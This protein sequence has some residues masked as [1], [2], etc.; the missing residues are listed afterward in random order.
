[1]RR[2]V[3]VAAGSTSACKCSSKQSD[4]CWDNIARKPALC[5]QC[6]PSTMQC[7][8]IVCY[9]P[10]GAPKCLTVR[11]GVNIVGGVV[12]SALVELNACSTGSADQTWTQFDGIGRLQLAGSNSAST[13][14]CLTTTQTLPYMGSSVSIQPC[15]FSVT[16]PWQ[17]W[18]LDGTT[19]SLKNELTGMCLSSSSALNGEL[20]YLVDCL[21]IAAPGSSSTVDGFAFDFAG[22][23]NGALI[24]GAFLTHTAKCTSIVQCSQLVKAP[25]DQPPRITAID[26]YPL[27]GYLLTMSGT[28]NELL[29]MTIS[30]YDPNQFDQVQIE[31]SP[32]DRNLLTDAS[33]TWPN[34]YMCTDGSNCTCAS[35]EAGCTACPNGGT[36]LRNTEN[37]CPANP[38]TRTFTWLP[39]LSTLF[40]NPST[41]I[42]LVSDIPTN[43]YDPTSVTAPSSDNPLQAVVSVNMP[44]E[45]VAPTP[46]YR[47][48]GGSSAGSEYPAKADCLRYCESE[49]GGR[50]EDAHLYV[51]LGGTLTFTVRAANRQP[52]TVV[53]IIFVGEGPDRLAPP[54]SRLV[55]SC[56]PPSTSPSPPP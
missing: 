45:F 13:R 4:Y 37:P 5:S 23:H 42:F 27:N 38:C 48:I 33:V 11:G 10:Y 18:S 22:G 19:L 44:P 32:Y 43:E 51:A 56:L 50:C 34:A 46:P 28:V 14:M 53:Q 52:G 55:V 9:G 20:P 49:G 36:C 25:I 16:R 2:S 39:T 30:S 31:F 8:R 17:M 29:E 15:D 40:S 47:C 6:D 54:A 35:P 1:M 41:F 3:T 12:Q 26:G 21:A 24:G 7:N